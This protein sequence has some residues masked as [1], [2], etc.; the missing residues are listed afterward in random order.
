[1]PAIPIRGPRIDLLKFDRVLAVL[2]TVVLEIEVWV[3]GAAPGHAIA[4]AL[5]GALMTGLVAIRRPYPATA[6]VGAG[7]LADLFA[8]VWGP[9]SLISYGVAWMCCM[10]GLA[11]WARPRRFAL[12]LVAVMAASVL[13]VVGP[14]TL[15]NTLQFTIITM[16]AMLLVRR[17]V[18]DRERRAQLAE[19]ERD[20]AVR[21]AMLDERARIAREM[22]DVIAH[23]VSVMVLQA[24]AERR[25]LGEEA[26]AHARCWRRSSRRPWRAGRDATDAGD[27]G[28]TTADPL[29]PQPGLADVPTLVG[30]L[31]EAGLPVELG[32]DGERRELPVGIELSAYR[33]VQEALT[34]ALKHAGDAR[35]ASYPLRQRL[36]RAGDQRRRRGRLADPP[37][38][39]RAGGD[40]RAGGHVRRPW[41]LA[42]TPAAGSPS[43]PAAHA[44]TGVLIVDD[45]ALVRV[46]LPKV[47]ES[48]PDM[49]VVGEAADGLAAVG[50]RAGCAPTWS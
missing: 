24:G 20:V 47:L 38:R 46:G 8:G 40:A 4:T 19:R 34:N 25:T 28:A 30:Q 1:M 15:F 49:T 50:R 21:E 7:L 17:V 18:G 6:G 31:R 13:S 27:A 10:Y 12:G 16:A 45:Q 32:I 11:V 9:P 35:A 3:G 39:P 22:H 33:I 14:V 29:A 43:A 36:A 5:L 48:E 23:H 26:G 37:R 42:P 41:T 44:M 2:L